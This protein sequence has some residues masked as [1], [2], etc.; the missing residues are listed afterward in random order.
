ML[1]EQNGFTEFISWGFF[2]LLFFLAVCLT[3]SFYL[4]HIIRITITSSGFVILFSLSLFPSP[5]SLHLK[6][7]ALM[8]SLHQEG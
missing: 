8:L 3:F 7:S 6:P 2:F 1:K 5:E 4:V